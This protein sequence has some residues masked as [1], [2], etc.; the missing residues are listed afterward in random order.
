V[1]INKIIQFIGTRP[2]IIKL[3]PELGDWYWTGQHYDKE[4]F[5]N[6]LESLGL[7]FPKGNLNATTLEATIIESQRIIHKEKPKIVVV[8]GDCMATLGVALASMQCGIKIAHI[9]AGLRSFEQNSIE[10]KIRKM[11]D[12]IS[13]FLFCSTKRAYDNLCGYSGKRYLVGDMMYQ[14]FLERHSPKGKILLTLHRRE[15]LNK[16]RITEIFNMMRDFKEVVF[17]CHPHTK[18][19]LLENKVELPKNISL[20]DPIN[21]LDMLELL[22]WTR[23]VFTDSGGLMREAY[24]SG[25]EVIPLINHSHKEIEE[26]GDRMV[27]SRIIKILKAEANMVNAIEEMETDSNGLI[28]CVSADMSAGGGFTAPGN[29]NSMDTEP[30]TT[31]SNGNLLIKSYA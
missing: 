9:E 29:L 8:Y 5:H 27:S 4:L 30:G 12:S 13:D 17:P 20:V 7:G 19:I 25:C 11:V 6:Q 10:E 26:F 14:R 1:A 2:Q 16:K 28:Q 21:Y 24:W 15:N 3:I 18:K 22:K 23:C 31:D